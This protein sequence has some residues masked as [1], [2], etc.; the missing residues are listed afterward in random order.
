MNSKI[1]SEE[2]FVRAK[3]FMADRYRNLDTVENAIKT[4]FESCCPLH[5]VYLLVQED[6]DYRLYVFFEKAKDVAVCQSNG[7]TAAIEVALY[8]ELER[9]KRG[10]CGETRVAFE[11]DS[12]ENVVDK[13]DGDYLS[14][15]R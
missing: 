3:Q 9:V 7:T 4:R 11:Y 1:P 5:G 13:F 6:V 14:R 15:L 12:H 8:E 2:D 10:K